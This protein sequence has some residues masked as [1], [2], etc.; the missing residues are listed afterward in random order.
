M[1]EI[2]LGTFSVQYDHLK[3]ADCSLKIAE[4]IYIK[5]QKLPSYFIGEATMSFFD[6]YAAECPELQQD[7]YRISENFQRIIKR[8]PHT[9][10]QNIL[11]E[12]DHY[13]MKKIPIYVSAKEYLI[14]KITPEK[15]PAF[16]DKV[17]QSQ[18]F[19]A[20]NV[21]GTKYKRLS[22][23]GTYG[24]REA[25]TDQDS[26]DRF[27]QAQ[28][29]LTNELYYFGHY[30]YAGMIQFLPEYGIETYDQFHEAYGKYIYSMTLTKAGQTIPLLW[31]DYLYH[32][33]ENH[34]EFGLLAGTDQTRYQLFDHWTEGE[35]VSI[36]ILAEG[37]EDVHFTTVLKKPMN[38]RP[39][40][41]ETDSVKGEQIT[42]KIAPELITEI[43]QQEAT[44]DILTPKKDT[45]DG[46]SLI[47]KATEDQ[48]IF[49]S[50]SLSQHGRYQLKIVSQTYGQLLFLFTMKQERL[51]E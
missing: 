9:N 1:K 32:K 5:E 21:D 26:N 35:E 15:Y 3:T 47:K 20:E 18:L 31:P 49:S 50:D 6:F 40:I 30:S 39:K 37:F 24:P 7:D 27:V 19:A 16:I 46:S 28:L 44:I 33:P 23:N 22:L 43:M 4:E 10:Q 38:S 51:E 2:K 11:S 41:V 14:A 48:L 25:L 42:L 45:L 13:S 29:E 36:E 34:L 17:E 12:D 8:F